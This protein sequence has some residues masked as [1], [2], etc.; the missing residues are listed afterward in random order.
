MF[1]LLPALYGWSMR[2]RIFHLYGELKFLE[3]E[4]EARGVAQAG[5]ELSARLEQRADH[6]HVPKSFAHFLYTLRL[7]IELVRARIAKA[8]A[9]G[10]R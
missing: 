5:P 9:S 1:R 3:A 10:Q 8:S 7:H 6:M 4:L 2:R